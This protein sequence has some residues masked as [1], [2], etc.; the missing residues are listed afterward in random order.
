VTDGGGSAFGGS[1]PGFRARLTLALV[2]AAVLPVAVFGIMVLLATGLS[3]EAGSALV[4]VLLLAVTVT[5][6]MAV[7]LAAALAADLA[8]PLRALAAFMERVS[9]GDLAA[10]LDIA[11]DDELGRLAE[12]HYQLARDLERRNREL[13]RLLDALGSISLDDGPDTIATRA[14]AQARET[15]G[16]I[17]CRLVLGGAAAEVPEEELVPGEAVPVRTVLTAGGEVMGVAAGHLPATRRWERADQDLFDLFALE[18]SAAIRNAQLYA[19]VEDQ[20]RRLVALDAAKD[21]FLRGISHNLQTPL[22][23][24][25]GY[26]AQLG[27]QAPDRRLDIIT[28]QADRLSR[29]VRQLLTVSRLASGAL[30][31]G[32]EVVL[33]APRVRRAWEA[34]GAADV[35]FSIDDRS[36]G[37]FAVADPDQLDQV[38]W[39][40]LDNAVIHG[41]RTPVEVRIANDPASGRIQ[42]T[43]ADHG[44]GVSETDRERLFGRFE[45][46]TGQPSGEGSGLG[47]FVAR[48]LVR[49]MEGELALASRA[50]EP[51]AAFTITLPGEAPTEA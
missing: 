33:P 38:L 50:D 26:A 22:A 21:D 2:A 8:R 45:R 34:L 7:L 32:Q 16:M 20:N 13:R 41:G 6:V 51:G 39:A 40:L 44:P 31:P 24:I 35:P 18:V 27:A 15:F 9:A 36:D 3:G 47:L 4:R 30:R 42:V 28:E 17:D 25:R 49:A 11:G 12:S 19:R 10:Q 29:M 43:I 1:G 5:V 14:G 46:G 23:S 48:E 37:W